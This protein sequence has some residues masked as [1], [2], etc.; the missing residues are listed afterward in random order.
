MYCFD[1]L[2]CVS[3]FI[4]SLSIDRVV[5]FF[6]DTATTEIYTYVHTLSLHDALPIC[7][8]MRRVALCPIAHQLLRH[9]QADTQRWRQCARAHPLLLP[10][11]INEI[12]RAHV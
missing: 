7:I 3:Y 8:H 10:A 11:A 5:F 12:G 6:N 1:C 2:F 4:I 9:A